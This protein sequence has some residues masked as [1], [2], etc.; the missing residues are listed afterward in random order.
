MGITRSEFLERLSREHPDAV[1][2]FNE[3]DGGLIHVEVAAFRQATEAA[4]DSGRLW[5]AEQ[6]FKLVEECL[7]ESDDELRN[8]LEVSYLGDFALG[9][10]TSARHAAVKSCMPK[11]LRAALVSICGDW[12]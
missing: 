3:H 5:V 12:K 6:H 9:E 8:A 4:I 11:S 7:A 10:C 2:Q 1:A